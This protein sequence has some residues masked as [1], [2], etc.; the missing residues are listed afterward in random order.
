MI[1]VCKKLLNTKLTCSSFFPLFRP[2][3]KE[4]VSA[5]HADVD[6]VNA[7]AVCS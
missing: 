4:K 1:S 3:S 6:S 2:R 7:C 5:M